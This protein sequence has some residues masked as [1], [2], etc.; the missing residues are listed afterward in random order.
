MMK[1]FAD[2][3]FW[4][5]LANEDDGLHQIA[6]QLHEDW[7]SKIIVTT[8]EILSEFLGRLSAPNH[9]PIALALLEVIR[10][11]SKVEVREQSRTSFNNGLEIYRNRKDKSCSLVDCVSF[12]VMKEENIYQAL[13]HDH[14]YE[15]E[16]FTA[17]M[18][19]QLQ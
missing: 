8:D 3:G 17:L 10:K 19:V 2:T 9:R 18:R 4:Y 16:G 5:A 1:V 11:N 15:Q 7:K 6:K 13:A 14:D 12:S